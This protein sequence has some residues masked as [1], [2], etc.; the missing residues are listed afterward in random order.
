MYVLLS[1]K[2]LANAFHPLYLLF[3]HECGVTRMANTDKSESNTEEVRSCCSSCE[4]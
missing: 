1:G 3:M 2:Y 4:L